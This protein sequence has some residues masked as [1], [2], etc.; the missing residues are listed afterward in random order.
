MSGKPYAYERQLSKASMFG[1]KTKIDDLPEVKNQYG[2]S[3]TPEKFPF[4]RPDGPITDSLMFDENLHLSIQLNDEV[5]LYTNRDVDRSKGPGPL[6]FAKPFQMLSEEGI[7]AVRNELSIYE[8][9]KRVLRTAG[10]TT[11]EN[12]LGSSFCLRGIAKYSHFFYDLAN[13]TAMLDALS[14]MAGE[15]IVPNSYECN[16]SHV[17]Y[18]FPTGE[19]GGKKIDQW[20]C[21]SIP[22]VLVIIA[23]DVGEDSIGGNLECVLDSKEN[24]SNI[25]KV[26]KGDVP[27]NKKFTLENSDIGKA[28]FMQ[29]S[30]V[31]HHVSSLEK[32]NGP[33]ISLVFSFEAA[34]PFAKN[35]CTFN[36]TKNFD[37]VTIAYP[38]YTKQF[39]FRIAQQL[40][41]L[42][43]GEI[44]IKDKEELAKFIDAAQKELK[45]V[46]AII[47]GKDDLPWIS[48]EFEVCATIAKCTKDLDSSDSSG[49]L[50]DFNDS[51]FSSSSDFFISSSRGKIKR[52]PH[53]TQ[54][55]VSFQDEINLKDILFSQ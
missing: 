28:V 14:L 52:F 37:P 36:F 25:I 6:A 13:S 47:R 51:D 30:E 40:M 2:V 55:S 24:A 29:G 33:R 7:K 10:N 32:A 38:D 27:L 18:G 23:S 41:S 3:V 34:D 54:R 44:K 53:L 21:D 35:Q 39:A 4:K 31:V 49:E 42:V 1:L 22:Y 11:D 5:Y 16:L 50:K 26:N 20:H 12:R 8:T 46:S 17:N 9:D 43:R 48:P 45:E 15:R 19:K